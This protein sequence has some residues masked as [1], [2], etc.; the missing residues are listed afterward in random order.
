MLSRILP[1]LQFMMCVNIP[2]SDAACLAHHRTIIAVLCVVGMLPCCHFCI[3]Q[4]EAAKQAF[5]QEMYRARKLAHGQKPS[6]QQW[7]AGQYAARLEA[8]QAFALDLAAPSQLSLALESVQV[9]LT[10]AWL[11]NTYSARHL[12]GCQDMTSANIQLRC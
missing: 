2:W 7:Q 12:A 1:S 3:I 8:M 10:Q 11:Y 9:C 6:Q 4:V 5:G